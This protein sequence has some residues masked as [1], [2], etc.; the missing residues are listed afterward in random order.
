[1]QLRVNSTYTSELE[2]TK[3]GIPCLWEESY[4]ENGVYNVFTIT[5]NKGRKI[6]PLFIKSN[7]RQTAL[8]P[9][10]IG[11][12]IV[13][14]CQ[15]MCSSGK[16]FIGK[17]TN[18]QEH[19]AEYQIISVIKN[20]KWDN[21]V[22]ELTDAIKGIKLAM[23]QTDLGK[24]IYVHNTTITMTSKKYIM[25]IKCGS[26]GLFGQVVSVAMNLYDHEK[27]IID[28][29]YCSIKDPVLSNR[30]S[31]DNLVNINEV[32]NTNQL[33]LVDNYQQ[34][35]H[36]AQIFYKSYIK[37]SMVLADMPY[38]VENNF[39]YNLTNRDMDMS[40]YPI[41]DLSSVLIAKGYGFNQPRA[42]LYKILN[43]GGH[44]LD[45]AQ[46]DPYYD[47]TLTANLYFKLMNI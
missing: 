33:I 19:K 30:W 24:P 39:I 16:I 45:N 35:F 11:H 9:I 44:F 7:C 29:M 10:Q 37:N 47:A 32:T 12:Y 40:P 31:I 36:R 38:P 22:I 17:I 20:N 28:N 5:N 14:G 3:T 15:S 42:E 2:R 43:N 21:Y 25:S 26:D 13:Y 46:S 6:K 27:S 8:L 34:L 4:I 1:M 41:V 23:I 18:I